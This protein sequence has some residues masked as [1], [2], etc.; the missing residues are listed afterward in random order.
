MI[1]DRDIAEFVTRSLD[2]RHTE[3]NVAAITD[4][5]HECSRA[6][7]TNYPPPHLFRT[8]VRGYLFK[9]D[10]P[11]TPARPVLDPVVATL[12]YATRHG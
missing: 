6:G 5:I 12:R 8:R 3:F 9:V 1:T 7:P 11:M 4:E 2:G 10:V